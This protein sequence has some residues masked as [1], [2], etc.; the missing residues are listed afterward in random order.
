MSRMES[1]LA[2]LK[3][4]GAEEEP[5]AAAGG[6]VTGI[7]LVQGEPF[8]PLPGQVSLAEDEHTRLTAQATA[9]KTALGAIRDQILKDDFTATGKQSPK[10]KAVADRCVEEGDYEHLCELAVEQAEKVGKVFKPGTYADRSAA[11]QKMSDGSPERPSR[12]EIE[13]D[14]RAVVARSRGKHIAIGTNGSRR[15]GE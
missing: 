11:T 1:F 4:E 5:Q 2:W 15:G 13:A 10:L 14:A 3:G 8:K 7:T 9:G 6:T 12:E